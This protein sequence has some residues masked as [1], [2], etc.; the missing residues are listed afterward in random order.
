[1]ESCE[2]MAIIGTIVHCCICDEGGDESGEWRKSFF[3][4]GVDGVTLLHITDG[5]PHA[6]RTL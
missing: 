2:A 6:L 3:L 5:T 4:Y 1:M